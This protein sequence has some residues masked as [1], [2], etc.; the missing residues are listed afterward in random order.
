[1]MTNYSLEMKCQL[2]PKGALVKHCKHFFGTV[3]TFTI[4][5]LEKID[6]LKLF[7]KCCM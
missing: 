2:I 4:Y 7:V 5:P 1:M 3:D 6:F